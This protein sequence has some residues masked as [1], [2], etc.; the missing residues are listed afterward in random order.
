MGVSAPCAVIRLQMRTRS[1]NAFV[2]PMAVA[3]HSAR[4]G[5][6]RKSRAV[7]VSPPFRDTDRCCQRFPAGHSPALSRLCC[8]GVQVGDSFIL[9][10][11]CLSRPYFIV[12]PSNQNWNL[13]TP[14]GKNSMVIQFMLSGTWPSDSAS[15][16]RKKQQ[17][18]P[19]LFQHNTGRRS[20]PDYQENATS[21][22]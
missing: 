20:R 13:F 2:L 15:Q 5:S 3:F 22:G 9:A 6:P 12:N 17:A 16:V 10:F 1:Q 21:F 18:G 7:M 14:Q 11:S 4:I 19:V 8:F